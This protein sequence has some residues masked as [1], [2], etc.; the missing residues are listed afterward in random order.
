MRSLRKLLDV[1]EARRF[2][3]EPP[4]AVLAGRERE[5]GVLPECHKRWVERA[6]PPRRD[7]ASPMDRTAAEEHTVAMATQPIEEPLVSVQE[8]LRA[9]YEPD[10]DYVD[11]RLEDRHVGEHDH[12]YLQILLGTIFTNNRRTW[13][14]HSVTD[15]RVQVAPT[16]FRV[17]DVSVLRATD[18]RTPVLRQPPL[19]AIEI[20]SPE[21]RLGRFTEKLDD[22]VSFG[23]PHI[24]VFDPQKRR[25]AKYS[26]GKLVWMREGELSVPGT[27]IRLDIAE[28]FAELDRA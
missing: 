22:Y 18:P 3:T 6:A 26:E 5:W 10:L 17:P 7:A 4:K 15:V 28:L 2:R 12:G 11:G 23:V 9:D 13:G 19:I 25:A 1:E 16:R 14:V 8:Y 24:W 27:P 20:L 21:D